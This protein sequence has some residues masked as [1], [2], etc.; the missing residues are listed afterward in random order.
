VVGILGN[1]YNGVYDSIWDT[2]KELRQGY[3]VSIHEDEASG[4]FV[5][6]FQNAS[7]RVPPFDFRLETVLSNS[8]A[9]HKFGESVCGPGFS[10]FDNATI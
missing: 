2:D 6:P 5:A 10:S 4:G 3:Q 9:G 1:H 7:G 8:A